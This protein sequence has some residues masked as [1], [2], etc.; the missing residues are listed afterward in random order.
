MSRI[1]LCFGDSNTHGTPPIETPG[2][3]ARY[4]AAT[5]WPRVTRAAL[6]DGWELVEEGLPG[7]TAQFEDPVMG[8][9]MDGR[10]GLSIALQS[11]GPIDALTLMVGTNDVKTRFGATAEKV[12]AGIAGLLDIAL[13]DDMQTRHHGFEVLLICPPPVKETGPC[14]GEFFGGETVSRS[15]APLYAGLAK[16]RGISF[17]NAGD[18]IEVSAIDGVHYEAKA[19]MALGQ[20][21]AQAV[22]MM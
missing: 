13:G 20:A 10:L 9:F 6:G 19:H 14:A 7:R 4:D 3:Y 21:V 2:T 15:L 1:L 12:T 8:T 18:L 16:A 17:L 22:L 11:H 5:R